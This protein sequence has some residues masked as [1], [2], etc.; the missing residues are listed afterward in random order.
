MPKLIRITFLNFTIIIF[1]GCET[2][3]RIEGGIYEMKKQRVVAL[4]VNNFKNLSPISF[5]QI[6]VKKEDGIKVGSFSTNKDGLFNVFNLD[7]NV[8]NC[9]VFEIKHDGNFDVVYIKPMGV[10]SKINILIFDE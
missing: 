4:A 8:P 10:Y 9:L 1:S 2:G 3:W 5:A 7:F 6:F